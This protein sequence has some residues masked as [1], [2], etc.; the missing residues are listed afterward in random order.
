MLKR[1]ERM[2]TDTTRK[3]DILTE[4]PEEKWIGHYHGETLAETPYHDFRIETN[5]TTQYW[6]K[7][8][9]PLEPQKNKQKYETH[10]LGLIT[11]KEGQL[12]DFKTNLNNRKLLKALKLAY[13]FE[14]NVC[15]DV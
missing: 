6:V 1:F 13:E 12:I 9:M 15:F 8:T 3:L 5:K 14:E 10:Y 4:D 11:N 7:L 2:F